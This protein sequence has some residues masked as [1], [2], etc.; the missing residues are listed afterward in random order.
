[1]PIV[2]LTDEE[3]QSEDLNEVDEEV[4]EAKTLT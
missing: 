3:D 4:N 1:M 2:I